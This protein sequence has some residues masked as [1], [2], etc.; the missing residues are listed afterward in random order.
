MATLVHCKCQCC[1]EQ[2]EWTPVPYSAPR[3]DD[4]R[5]YCL[6]PRHNVFGRPVPCRKYVAKTGA[7]VRQ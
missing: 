3:C 4:C 5:R 7:D 1:G 6:R 2:I